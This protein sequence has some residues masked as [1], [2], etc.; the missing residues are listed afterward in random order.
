[1]QRHG[2]WALMATLG[3][4][5]ACGGD[6]SDLNAEATSAKKPAFLLGADGKCQLPDGSACLFGDESGPP[7]EGSSGDDVQPPAQQPP[8]QLPPEEGGCWV[9]GIGT[10][11]KGVTRDSFGGNAMTMKD[12]RV[13]GEWQHTD[14]FDASGTQK[15]GQN[16]FHGQVTYLVCKSY[17]SLSGPE[18]PKAVPN[19]ANWGGTGRFNGVDGY[20]FDVTAFDH[21]EG[22]IH[23]DRYT[24]RIY[25]AQHNLVLEAD[26]R[27]T[28]EA[29][30]NK[31][32]LE[33]PSVGPELAWV[34]EM[35]C[36][37]GGN[38][39]IHPPNQGHPY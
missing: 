15:N 10:F 16:L 32:C 36:L 14:H 7:I 1:M 2:Y 22:G 26:G 33:D 34:K 9:T 12:G 18:V 38:F 6:F 27:G 4:V 35:G 25:D 20:F 23:R 17:P 5:G 31:S 24:I 29:P 21:A 3:L 11:G 8:A 19:Y 28:M 37:S 39:Q 13:R 30:S